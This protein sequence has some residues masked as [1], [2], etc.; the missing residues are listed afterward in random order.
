MKFRQHDNLIVGFGH[1]LDLKETTNDLKLFISKFR[2]LIDIP[3][4]L[5][6]LRN[7]W[8]T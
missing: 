4:I 8:R 6:K 7:Y 1:R 2:G 5:R 3:I